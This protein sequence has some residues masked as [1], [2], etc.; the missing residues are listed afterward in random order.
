MKETLTKH[1]TLV[2][3]AAAI[4]LCA[5]GFAAGMLAKTAM[6]GSNDYISAN[7]AK[8]IALENV[9]VSQ[10]KATFTMAQLDQHNSPAV[11]DIE[12]HSSAY[13]YEFKI[14]ACT[15]DIM[16]KTARLLLRRR[17]RE[18]QPPPK[19]SRLRIP[20]IRHHRPQRN[21]LVLTKRKPL[22]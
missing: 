17:I 20:G 8:T 19:L 15:G 7:K 2:I 10:E 13:E 6:A 22:L 11:Y 18:P 1:K 21:T 3:I 12:F 4:A 5:I 16:K 14:H 9:G